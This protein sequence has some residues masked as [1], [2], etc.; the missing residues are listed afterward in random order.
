MGYRHRLGKRRTAG[1]HSGTPG[2]AT[3][4]GADPAAARET[5]AD[6]ALVAFTRYNG[7]NNPMPTP[8]TP[9]DEVQ[10]HPKIRIA[11]LKTAKPP[12]FEREGSLGTFESRRPS[13]R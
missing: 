3:A 13:I 6:C 5:L 9:T 4:P 1:L 12:R 8:G 11:H 7:D 2:L 10:R